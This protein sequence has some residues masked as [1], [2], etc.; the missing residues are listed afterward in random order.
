MSACRTLDE[1]AA[2][3]DFCTNRATKLLII[4]AVLLGLTCTG[5]FFPF[6]DYEESIIEH[7]EITYKVSYLMGRNEKYYTIENRN[8]EYYSNTGQKID[9]KLIQGLAESF[10]D[11]YE[12]DNYETGYNYFS[13]TDFYP[14]FTVVVTHTAGEVVVKSDSNF[15]CFIPWN[16]EY[17][18][19]AYVQYNGA[20]PSALLKILVEMDEYWLPYEKYVQW[21]CYPAEVPDRYYGKGSPHFPKST[22][23]VTPEEEKGVAHVMWEQDIDEYI[24]GPPLYADGKVFVTVR[25]GV[26]CFDAE[27]GERVWEACLED[28]IQAPIGD[29]EYV[30]YKDGRL[31]VTVHNG[32]LCFD[33]ETGERVWE[34]DGRPV[35]GP[36]VHWDSKIFVRI[37]NAREL[38]ITPWI[39]GIM[40]LDAFTGKKIWEFNVEET[41]KYSVYINENMHFHDG[42]I[43]FGTGEPSVYCLDAESGETI[44]KYTD[45]ASQLKFSGDYLLAIKK[46]REGVVCLERETGEKMWE[47]NDMKYKAVYDDIIRMEGFDGGF[48]EVLIHI[49]SG[50][51]LWKGEIY[52]GFSTYG[53]DN[54]ILYFKA[55]GNMLVAF[56]VKAMEELWQYTHEKKIGR[57]NIFDQGILVQIMNSEDKQVHYTETLVFLDKNGQLLWEHTYEDI[58][59]GEVGALMDCIL[60]VFR[61]KGVVEAFDVET[62]AFLWKI[63]VRGTKITDITVYEERL[64]ICA[65]D[66]M[67]YCITME[68]GEIVWAVDT[69][70]RLYDHEGT[71][72]PYFFQVND[73]LFVYTEDG[74]I[75]AI[76]TD[77]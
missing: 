1:K 3:L 57:L 19:K 47:I 34:A 5:L 66:G 13:M 27:T 54:G 24:I 25:K 73:V 8:G 43:Y 64:Y 62:G 20:I 30:V 49:T 42:E 14:R 50:E 61:G 10:T 53:Y 28:S 51:L 29:E 45:S 60:F 36:P 69:K 21:G 11:F 32:L 68:H 23:V 2:I 7:I 74:T 55:K 37:K 46:W 44:W 16:I 59:Y 75:C 67:V 4:T 63:E 58:V 33:A 70:S 35:I 38:Y 41:K 71:A 76:S 65:N 26:F 39:M 17:N 22:V 52:G 9:V 56:D 18:G 72:W 6:S 15:H 31:F 12:S 48:Y 77:T 40:C